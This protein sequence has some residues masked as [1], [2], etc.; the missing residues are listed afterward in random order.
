[1]TVLVALDGSDAGYELLTSAKNLA[2]A[3]GRTVRAVH[4]RAADGG[5]HLAIP[6]D[7]GCAPPPPKT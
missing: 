5:A 2:V 4:V 7:L 1:M 3:A 6:A